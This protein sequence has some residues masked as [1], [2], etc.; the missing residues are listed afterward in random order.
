VT[1]VVDRH[2]RVPGN[3]SRRTSIALLA[4]GLITAVLLSP[5]VASGQT[6]LRRFT[7]VA[8][9]DLLVHGRVADLAAV[10][11]AP[12][13]GWDFWPMLEP[14][15]PWV[16]S[17]DLALCHFEGTI[18]S[19]DTG[20][21]YYPRFVA[22]NSIA[23]A[24]AA[25]GWDGCSTA[26]NHGLDAGI[27]GVNMTLDEFD[28]RGIGHSGTARTPE[29]RLPR[30]YDVEGVIVA[31]LAF[32]QHY[33]GLRTPSDMTWAANLID[34]DQILED[35]RWARQQG[36]EFV[37]L[38]VSWGSEYTVDPI[39][40]QRQV[41]E[42]ILNDPAVDLIIGHH[43]HIVEPIGMINDKY[44]VYSMGNHLSNQNVFWGPQYYGT[45]DGLMV[46]AHVAEQSDGSFVTESME[47][48]PTWVRFQDLAVFSAQ[49]ALARGIASETVLTNSID[50]TWSRVNRLGAPGI[51]LSQDPHPAVSC[52]NKRATVLGTRGDDDLAGTDGPDV[53]VGRDGNDT[54]SALAG[55]DII[56]A[57]A[58]DDVVDAGA[59]TDRVWGGSGADQITGSGPLDVFFGGTGDDMC[60][61]TSIV[62]ICE[63]P[64]P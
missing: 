61:T 64:L 58:G 31:H 26:T 30:L 23:D 14:I 9:G 34:V 20:L 13:G 36:A 24:I 54:I 46:I 47:V 7:I 48:V 12:G 5:A 42:Q 8:A 25:A 17:A 32:S 2:R 53:I 43:P 19:T 40:Y 45:E 44:V 1:H 37:V 60:A 56:C 27:S 38:S 59:G 35:A 51:W 49:D 63:N 52:E 28:A 15:E 41:A 62:V 11:A 22:P 16:S 21:S 18:S 4:V 55:D 29:E 3:R 33:N 6:E 39:S 50:R 10:N 57:G